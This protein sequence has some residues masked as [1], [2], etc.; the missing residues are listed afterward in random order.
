MTQNQPNTSY[1]GTELSRLVH[2]IENT[3]AQ[4]VVP[5][6]RGASN[7]LRIGATQPIAKAAG[8]YWLYTDYTVSEIESCATHTSKTNAVPIAELASLHRDLP[9]ISTKTELE[10]FRVV[11]NGIAGPT[12]GVLGRIRQHFNGGEGTG[13]L[14][15]LNTSLDDL[16][17]WRISYVLF[18]TSDQHDVNIDFATHAKNLERMWR[19]TFG[20]PLLCRH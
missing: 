19:L 16:S 17:R 12:L 5:I 11:Y 9:Y 4:R 14:N 13:C 1:S 18:G 2:E 10:R 7:R 3:R 20:W 15:I 6:T 8:I